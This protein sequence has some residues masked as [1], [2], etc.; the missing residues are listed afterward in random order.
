MPE[1]PEVQTTVTGLSK[2]IIGLSIKDVWTDYNS[3]FFKGSETIKDPIYF[4]RFKK[5]TT[6]QK[7]VDVSRRAKNILI[8][9][10][11]GKTLLI[12]MKMTGHIMIGRYVF[13]E[14]KKKD[15]W[16][17]AP[18]ERPALHDP[19]NR[20]I[21]FV[22]TLS[23]KKHLVLSDVRKFAKVTLIENSN[24]AMMNDRDDHLG[25]LGPEP[26]DKS[27]SFDLFKERLNKRLNG[28]IKTVLMD[29]SIISGVGNIYSDE[30][31]FRASIHPETRVAHVSEDALK[32]LYKAT[33][34]VL[35]KGIDFGGDSTSDY[36][37]IH[38]ERGTFQAAHQ[39]YRRTGEPCGAIIDGK[40]CKGIIQRKVVGGRSAHF[41]SVHQKLR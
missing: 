27:F 22:V 5:E 9:L 10:D 1:L 40:K 35:E 29:Q 11:S 12:H 16:S 37:N 32:R 17:P 20:H 24:E 15:P 18:E 36:R 4:K 8:R 13:D 31:L 14:K 38:G 28:K 26:L 2:T 19:F 30:A 21:H 33:K 41:C 25:G 23:N 7:I 6:G 39:A 34:E 3:P